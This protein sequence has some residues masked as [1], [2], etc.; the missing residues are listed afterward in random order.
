M[1]CYVCDQKGAETTAVGLRRRCQVA[2]CREHLAEAQAHRAGGMA[3][4]GCPHEALR[5]KTAS[6]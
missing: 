1:N 3:A 5:V 6:G 2:L 4:Y